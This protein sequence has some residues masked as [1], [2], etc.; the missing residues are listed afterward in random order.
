M[1]SRYAQSKFRVGLLATLLVGAVVGLGHIA[2][3]AGGGGPAAAAAAGT[4]H[5]NVFFLILDYMVIGVLILASICSIA[6]IIDA[7]IHVRESRILPEDS[8]E[9]I[10]T[11]INARQ[12]DELMEFTGT[13]DSF[14]SRALHTAIRRAHLGYSAMREGLESSTGEQ[15][16]NLFRRIELLNVIGNIGPLIGLLGTVLGMIMAF[17]A[18][19]NANG[20]AKPAQLAGGISVAL[21]HTF[22]GL[23]VAIPSL[24]VFGFYRTKIDKITMKASLLSEELLESLRPDQKSG[25]GRGATA[26]PSP[27]RAA[28]SPAPS[29]TSEA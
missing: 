6:L 28:P 4:G 8:T 12:F 18:L 5:V 10:R 15:T 1:F 23:A 21:W 25:E 2:M 24:V 26:R 14:V 11:L 29:S 7:A 13:D 22:G 20:A 3:A 16:S 19:H 27:R 17:E 9:H